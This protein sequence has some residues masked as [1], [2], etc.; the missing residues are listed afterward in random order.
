MLRLILG[1]GLLGLT[2]WLVYALVADGPGARHAVPASASGAGAQQ[3]SPS[4]NSA[5]N[6][7]SVPT[8]WTSSA[9]CRDC[10]TQIFDEW[11]ASPHAN[12]WNNEDVRVQSKD[13]SNKVCI[14]C[15]APQPVWE[16]G[17]GERVMPRAARRAEGV[18]CLTCHLLPDGRIAGTVEN[19]A[20]PCRP[21]IRRELQ[22]VDFCA[23]CHDQHKTVQQWKATPFAE[24]RIG[25]IQCHMPNRTAD[26]ADGRVH[27]MPGGHYIEVVR[28]AVTLEATARPEGGFEVAVTNTGAG[29]SY[30]TDERSRASDLWWRPVTGPAT[31][32]AQLDANGV[33][34]DGGD[35]RHLHR[36]RDPYRDETHLVSTLLMYG[37]RRALVIDD[38][39]AA[40]GVEVALVYKR[41]PYYR[42]P[43]TGA[44]IA[45]ESVTDPFIDSEL[46][47]RVVARP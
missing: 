44:P 17:I 30:P 33:T 19:P 36:I 15:H 38:P 20:A 11:L 7:A 41:A 25:C 24:E 32:A 31:D 12:S 45:T 22:R 29:H 34:K 26:P 28:S 13:F 16:S 47:Q 10:H 23:G 9:Q 27:T 46:V 8:E 37:E 18:D 40:Q 3:A 14:D 1:L 42:D 2:G 4:A 35:W 21:T 6:V 43:T 39:D 5:P